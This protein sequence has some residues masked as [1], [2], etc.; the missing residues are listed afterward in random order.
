MV[1]GESWDIPKMKEIFQ[2][3]MK[4][5]DQIS[6]LKIS[7][8]TNCK[9]RKPGQATR[10]FRVAARRVYILIRWMAAFNGL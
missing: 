6:G 2:G 1:R 4:G 10:C 7:R 5:I 9:F 3:S 8:Q